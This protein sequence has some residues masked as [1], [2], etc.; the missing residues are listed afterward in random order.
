MARTSNSRWV[1]PHRAAAAGTLRPH[2]P[3]HHA[4]D[5]RAAVRAAAARHHAPVARLGP[6]AG[7]AYAVSAQFNDSGVNEL[8]EKLMLVT[9]KKT[10]NSFGDITIHIF[11]ARFFCVRFFLFCCHE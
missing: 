2:L 6:R 1:R 10:G 4:D 11:V 9:G 3:L 8:F 7:V 5:E